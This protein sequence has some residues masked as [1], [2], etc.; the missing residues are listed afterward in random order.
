MGALSGPENEHIDEADVERDLAHCKIHK[1]KECTS[2][3]VRVSY[4]LK[5]QI[6][7]DMKCKKTCPKVHC[8][9]RCHRT[10]V[11]VNVAPCCQRYRQCKNTCP[12]ERRRCR[13][14][15]PWRHRRHCHNECGHHQPCHQR[16]VDRLCGDN[17]CS[18]VCDLQDYDLGEAAIALA[19]AST[20]LLA[21]S[22]I[23]SA[24]TLAPAS[25]VA[26]ASS[27][28]G[29]TAD[30]ATTSADIISRA[31]SAAST[32]SAAITSAAVSATFK[33]TT[34]VKLPSHS[35]VRQRGSLLPALSPVQEHLPLRA[36]SL[37]RPV[38]LETPPTL[39]QRV[40]T[41]SAVPSALRRPSL[42]R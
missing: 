22:A 19:C 37:T 35:R 10:R 26:D 8:V 7:G 36:P 28:P 23:A 24:R 31:I 21:A 32:V 5:F 17:Q 14:Q 33:T 27:A 13:V 25:A 20:W 2:C 38:P 11:C 15:C 30:T 12:C 39:P 18:S 4:S 1:P 6:R 40:R 16:C 3:T 42:R 34:S 9:R 41:S 29:D